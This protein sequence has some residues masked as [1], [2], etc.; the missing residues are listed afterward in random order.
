M[1][2]GALACLPA[3]TNSRYSRLCSPLHAVQPSLNG[4]AHCLLR[5][6]LPQRGAG[7]QPKLLPLRDS[8]MAGVLSVEE[9]RPHRPLLCSPLPPAPS[10][11]CRQ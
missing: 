3:C 6:W 9:G 5:P 11:S 4:Q 8:S 10:T 7:Y 1:L 2:A